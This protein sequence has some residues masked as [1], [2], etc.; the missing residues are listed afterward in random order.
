MMWKLLQRPLDADHNWWGGCCL[1]KTLSTL[2]GRV[3]VRP[4]YRYRNC[5]LI[6]SRER[7]KDEREKPSVQDIC[8]GRSGEGGGLLGSNEPPFLQDSFHVLFLCY[9]HHAESAAVFGHKK[10]PLTSLCIS[11]LAKGSFMAG[12]Q[13]TYVF[14]WVYERQNKWP[15]FRLGPKTN[16]NLV[17]VI[18]FL[19]YIEVTFGEGE[20]AFHQ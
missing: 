10:K 11:L 17:F 16:I 20:R 13:E 6:P 2:N 19:E 9:P 3:R 12:N 14:R 1:A 18:Q 5:G 15:L 4:R 8:R 7:S